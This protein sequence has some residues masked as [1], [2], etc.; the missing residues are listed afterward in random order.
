MKYTQPIVRL[1]HLVSN[2]CIACS[3]ACRVHEVQ[4]NNQWAGV[5][6][7]DD[8]CPVQKTRGRTRSNVASAMESAKVAPA[9]A[10]DG[11]SAPMASVNLVVEPAAS[12]KAFGSFGRNSAIQDF[13]RSFRQADIEAA[14]AQIGA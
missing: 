3:F 11:K 6:A 10:S 1:A 7:T 9:P 8:F 2:N 14:L 12:R 5:G 4:R 13:Q